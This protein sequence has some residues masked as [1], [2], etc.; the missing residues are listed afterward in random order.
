MAISMALEGVIGHQ[1]ESEAYYTQYH[2]NDWYQPFKQT[3]FMKNSGYGITP[4]QAALIG[5][6]KL[7][8]LTNALITLIVINLVTVNILCTYVK[9]Q[10]IESYYVTSRP[11]VEFST[12]LKFRQTALSYKMCRMKM[13]TVYKNETG[14]IFRTHHFLREIAHSEAEL[15]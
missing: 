11:P 1:D 3:G 15:L 6:V 8:F 9:I 13:L 4:K 5:L 14:R 12:D 10:L 7:G 2:E